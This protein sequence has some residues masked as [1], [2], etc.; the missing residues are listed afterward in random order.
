MQSLS[1]AFVLIVDGALPTSAEFTSEDLEV[2][3][4]AHFRYHSEV[5]RLLRKEEVTEISTDLSQLHVCVAVK[6][7]A[8]FVQYIILS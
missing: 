2:L 8:N 1:V 5:D 4:A 3:F 7:F 6:S